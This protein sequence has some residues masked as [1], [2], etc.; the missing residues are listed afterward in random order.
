MRNPIYI[1]ILFFSFA[2]NCARAETLFV[3]GHAG[4][5]GGPG[6]A[7]MPFLTLD[8]AVST[9]AK[10][11]GGESITIKLRPGLYSFSDILVLRTLT[12]PDDA[13]RYTIEAEILPDQSDWAP[14]KMPVLQSMSGNNTP[15]DINAAFPHSV[16]IRVARSNV[17]FRGLKF[18]GNPNPAVPYYYPI[19]RDNEN[20]RGLEIT[21]CYFVGDK[22]SAPLQ[23]GLLASGPGI[24][25]D[26]D[27]FYNCKNAFVLCW[28]IE[29]LSV[30][31]SV[32]YGQYEAVGWIGKVEPPF[33]FSNNIVS[34]E[35]LFL[36]R[37][38]VL[39]NYTRGKLPDSATSFKNYVESPIQPSYILKNSV[40]ERDGY[41]IGYVDSNGNFIQDTK[42]HIIENGIRSTGNVILREATPDGNP[43]DYLNPTP[44]SAGYD[45][46]AGIFMPSRK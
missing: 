44:E 27:V 32:M 7:A 19:S 6:T 3:D 35:S 15:M 12:A 13:P 30:T 46:D 4:N 10:L 36:V 29:D 43:R 31:H 40:I 11:S 33:E 45:L 8:K 20:L 23:S 26:H 25:I 34:H 39:P 2:L 28:A 22:Y 17:T 18:I 24:K 38:M 1:P 9:A 37:L 21:Q 41:K 5:D 16:G 42:N 14:E